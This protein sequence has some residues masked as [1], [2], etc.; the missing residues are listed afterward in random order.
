MDIRDWLR[1]TV[2]IDASDLHLMAGSPPIVRVW[3][4][5]IPLRQEVLRPEDTHALAVSLLSAEQRARFEERWDLD[6]STGLAGSGRFRVNLYRQRGTV[7]IAIR[8]VPTH[9]PTIE[10]LNL[11]PKLKDLCRLPRGLVLVTGATGQ[12]KSTTLAA[13]LDY[14]NTHRT[15]NV[16]TI[17]DPIEYIHAN[18]RS[19]FN[20][21]EVGEDTR[22]FAT[23]LRAGLREDP[24]VIMVGEMRDLETIATALTIAETGHLVFATLHTA[25]A[26]QSVDRII[27]VFPPA[28]QQQTRVQLAGVIEAVIS[29]QLLPNRLYFHRLGGERD[30]ALLS[31]SRPRRASSAEGHWPGLE[32]AGRVPAVELLVATPAIR[33]LIR[34]SKTH[35][36]H[37]A[38]QTGGEY[39]MQTMDAALA[40]LVRR[41]LI[42]LE[43]ALGRAVYP[44]EVRRQAGPHPHGS[45][46]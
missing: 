46:R 39:G 14:I 37:S 28:Q 27:D 45:A 11:P 16:I 30:A 1:Q 10:Q 35:Q 21:R 26:G 9:I 3:G 44:E 38:I 6:F 17:E 24:D 36:I 29:Q 19:F 8:V 31:P 7:A 22:S 15:V 42:S 2:E 20:Q 5:L 40:G 12:G 32:D 25:T 33:N 13:M 4:D 41:R 18:K 34:E 43:D 23:A